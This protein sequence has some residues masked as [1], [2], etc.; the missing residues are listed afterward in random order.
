MQLLI[1]ARTALNWKDLAPRRPWIILRNDIPLCQW[2]FWKRID[3][4]HSAGARGRRGVD[5]VCDCRRGGACEKEEGPATAAATAIE[6]TNPV[7]PL[8][9]ADPGDSAR[10]EP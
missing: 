6:R 7:S 3:P 1:A 9:R 4:S 8:G 10:G 5:R 2:R